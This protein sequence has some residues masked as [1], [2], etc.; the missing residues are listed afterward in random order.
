MRLFGLALAAIGLLLT[1]AIFFLWR[2]AGQTPEW[3]SPADPAAPANVT[4]GE[5][6]ENTVVTQFHKARPAGDAT[7]TLDLSEE[8][9]NAWLATRLPRWAENRDLRWRLSVSE[10]HTAIESDRVRLGLRYGSDGPD[11]PAY[12]VEWRPVVESPGRMRVEV[13]R[14]AR[15]RLALPLDADLDLLGDAVSNGHA[16]VGDALRGEPFD[17]R[18]E[19]SDGRLV[20]IQ[21]L[22]L[23]PDR[24]RLTFKTLPDR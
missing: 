17:A 21:S 18:L 11:A 4:L 3:W 6:V 22:A 7:W 23:E 2:A 13:L 16:E 15:G 5:Y 14:L 20:E 9:I 8:W 24:I 10:A 19:L 12:S 1:I